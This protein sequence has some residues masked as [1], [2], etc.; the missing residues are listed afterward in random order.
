MTLKLVV[1]LAAVLLLV[2]LAP[3]EET[4]QS[5]PVLNLESVLASALRSHP[6]LAEARA[7]V[8]EADAGVGIASAWPN[9]RFETGV[10]HAKPAGTD[11]SGSETSW[12]LSQPFPWPGR[13][14][15]EVEAERASV[16]AAER[17]AARTMFEVREEVS[18]LFLDAYQAQREATVLDESAG[19]LEA[20]ASL[21]RQRVDIGE[22]RPLD[23]LRGET[24]AR[25]FRQDAEAAKSRAG[26]LYSQLRIAAGGDLALSARLDLAETDSADLPSFAEVEA[27]LQTDSPDLGEAAALAVEGDLRV[28]AE[29]RA[30]WPDVELTGYHNDEI[31]KTSSGGIV[32]LNLPVFWRN[33]YGVARAEARAIRIREEGRL[34]RI[35]RTQELVSS[36]ALWEAAR[37]RRD[38][39]EAE[40]LPGARHSLEIAEF[41]LKHGEATLLDVLDSRRSWLAAAQEAEAAR[42]EVVRQ[43]VRIERLLGGTLP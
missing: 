4:P 17:R 6:S 43:K 25:R 22:A 7:A 19:A 16:G 37:K 21:L 38:A 13:R 35:R 23:A 36:H 26:A 10:G 8:D 3:A 9:P 29:R 39:Y 20:L 32:T 1:L 40:I 14:H 12:G 41:S 30:W 5:A 11:M 34:E 28:R 27:R 15:A 24:E 31:D 2:S 33:R 18:L 42:V